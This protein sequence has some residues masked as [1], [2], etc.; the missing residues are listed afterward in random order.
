MFRISASSFNQP[1]LCD[2]STWN[3]NATT[4]SNVTQFTINPTR[5]FVSR[6]NTFYIAVDDDVSILS[7]IEGNINLSIVG[8]G[9]YSFFVSDDNYMYAYEG[10]GKKLITR[11]TMQAINGQTVKSNIDTCRGLFI[12]ANNTLY[13]SSGTHE[14]VTIPLNSSGS[15]PVRVAGNGTSGSASNQLNNPYGIF[16]DLCFNLYIADYGGNRVQR[17]SSG[18][19][20]ATTMA[21]PG[22]SGTFDL[23][24]PTDVVLDGNGYLFI[25]DHGK[26]RIV[27]SGPSGFRCV[28]GC[29]TAGN[30]PD[31]L[32]GPQGMSFDN[33]GNIWV[34]D[35]GN[36]RIQKFTLSTA[37]TGRYH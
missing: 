35:T 20:N 8:T 11:W 37:C 16:V 1:R 36:H 15:V 28:A 17:V 21:G 27:G 7:G 18:Q 13:C 5:I 26:N 30:A 14:V 31:Q 3:P 9:G 32:N 29:T 22:V 24:T 23:I 6:N 2:S 12:D 34:A 33:H 19:T 10:G 25:V 4:I